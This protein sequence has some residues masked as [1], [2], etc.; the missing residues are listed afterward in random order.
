MITYLFKLKEEYTQL[1]RETPDITSTS[2]LNDVRHK[3][4][5]DPR[6]KA[7]GSEE[8]KQKWFKEY[9]DD[10]VSVFNNKMNILTQSL[11]TNG[12]N[13][14]RSPVIKTIE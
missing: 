6:Y 10:M 14:Q 8:K 11:M 3:I 4:D 9:T 7:V 12:C 13:V 1:L 2:K 5:H